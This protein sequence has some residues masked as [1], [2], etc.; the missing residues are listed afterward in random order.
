MKNP[1]VGA[2]MAAIALGAGI[3]LY[4]HRAPPDITE[5]QATKLAE[6]QME[7]QCGAA[8]AGMP[9]CGDFNLAGRASP[10]DKRYKWGYRY[11]NVKAE[12]ATRIEIMIGQKGEMRVLQAYFKPDLPKIA[13]AATPAKPAAS[14]P[15]G[16]APAAGAKPGLSA[17]DQA[18]AAVLPP[19]PGWTLCEL[20]P[21]VP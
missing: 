8:E 10:E 7:K 9:R 18:K 21:G 13:A 14:T 15:A 1:I 19:P 16:A 4:T 11:E 17:A 2:L 6:V 12:R 3:Y 20:P 5:E